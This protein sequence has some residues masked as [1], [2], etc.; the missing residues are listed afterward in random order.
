[1]KGSYPMPDK[2]TIAA[3]LIRWH[4]KVEPGL[5]TVY[6]VMSDNEADPKEPIKLIE[7]NTHTVSSFAGNFEAFGFAPTR[8]VPFPTLIAEVTPDELAELRKNGRL[9]HGWAIEGAQQFLPVAA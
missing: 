2:D 1:M 7:V 3:E 5:V 6:R 9:P 8:D 4:F